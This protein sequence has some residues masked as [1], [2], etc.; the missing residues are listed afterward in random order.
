MAE[1]AAVQNMA[2]TA[3]RFRSQLRNVQHL[4]ETAAIL[5]SGDD[6]GWFRIWR[7]QQP[8]SGAIL[9]SGD[10][11]GWFRICRRQQPGSGAS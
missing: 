7:R 1:T 11:L 4:Q 10:N 8:G 9:E 6:W 5:E 2:E 3:A